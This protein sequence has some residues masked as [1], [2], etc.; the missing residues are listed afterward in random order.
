[1]HVP[2]WPGTLHLWQHVRRACAAI[3]EGHLSQQQM[4]TKTS[5][6]LLLYPPSPMRCMMTAA[7][8]RVHVWHHPID[9]CSPH[10]LCRLFMSDAEKGARQ[11]PRLL[12]VLW[13]T[14]STE[15]SSKPFM[16]K[17]TVTAQGATLS[18]GSFVQA[19]ACDAAVTGLPQCTLQTV[20]R[21]NVAAPCTCA[22]CSMWRL[23]SVLSTC[24]QSATGTSAHSA[25]DRSG[26]ALA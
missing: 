1:V 13:D 18:K 7:A 21:F 23:G 12:A 9:L 2:D 8:M 19:H 14:R 25:S 22:S 20:H 6:R 15:N 11:A 24:L 17:A 10:L 16:R 5:A 4:R 3:N 26:A